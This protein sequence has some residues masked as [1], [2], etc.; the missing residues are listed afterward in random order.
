MMP[1]MGVRISWLMLARKSRFCFAGLHSR[2]RPWQDAVRPPCY[3]RQFRSRAFEFLRWKRCKFS[4][5]GFRGGLCSLGHPLF[6]M[7]H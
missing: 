3:G 5:A 2:R 6:Q 7:S 4:R 1:F